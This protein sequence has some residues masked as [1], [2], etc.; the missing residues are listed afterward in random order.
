MD[1]PLIAMGAAIALLLSLGAAVF[2]SLRPRKQR[3][4][5]A[6]AFDWS[7]D[8]SLSDGH[9]PPDV[10]ALSSQLLGLARQLLDAKGTVLLSPSESGWKV[11]L[12]SP[13]M[14]ATFSRTLPLKEGIFGLAFDGEKEIAADPVHPPSVGYLP[15]QTEPVSLAVVPVTHRGRV[16]GLLACHR[17]AGQPFDEE[18]MAVLRRCVKLL[19]G[20]ES[21]ASHAA[22][23]ARVLDHKDRVLRGLEKMVSVSDSAPDEM[24]GHV[25]DALFDL[26]PATYGFCVIQDAANEAYS[27]DGKRFP[28][29]FPFDGLKENTWAYY[30]MAKGKNPLY[31]EGATSRDTAMPILHEGEP[32]PSGAIAYLCPLV[33]GEQYFGVVGVIGKP[34]EAFLERDRL[35]ADHFL[36]QAAALIQ[37]AAL[38]RF[39]EKNAIRDGLTGLHNRRHFQEQ[40]VKEESRSQREGT[41][42]SLIMLDIDHFKR[43]NDTHGHPAGDA[44]LK[45]VARVF[46]SAVRKGDMV[47]RYGGEEFVGILPV[48]PPQEAREVAE[49]VRKAVE[50]IPVTPA[51]FPVSV[52]V[53]AGV[54][55][56]PQPFS[57]L[58]GLLRGA[59][60]ALYAAKSKGRNRVEVASR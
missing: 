5:K 53:S 42:L 14:I 41:P 30:V 26:F 49:R 29:E 9:R 25:L 15:G 33:V 34:E 2:L 57:S 35:V 46:Q 28:D 44:V 6:E 21:Y 38:K 1:S 12:V 20:W 36:K 24:P 11:S 19:D 37:L 60:E 7:P 39:N 27:F 40:L 18:D 32:F 48:C 43:V 13:G 23:A 4:A 50:A 56:F 51:V 54:A 45:E 17:A 16:R 3:N 8:P 59:D 55:T 52:T 47:C 10:A 22:E 58:T 31:L